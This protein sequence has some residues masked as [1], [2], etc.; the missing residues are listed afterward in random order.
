MMINENAGKRVAFLSL[1]VSVLSVIIYF[2]VLWLL[3]KPLISWLVLG[4]ADKNGLTSAVKFDGDNATYQY[5]LGRYYH[6][7]LEAPDLDAAVAYYKKSLLLSPLQAGVWNDLS[8]VY[9]LSGRFDNAEYALERAVK[10]NPNDSSLMWQAGT[11]YLINGMTDKAVSVLKKYIIIEPDRQIDVYDLCWKLKLDNSYI[12]RNLVPAQYAYQSRYLK[13]LIGHKRIEE[14][15]EVWKVIDKASVEKVF[16]VGYVNF[17]IENGLYGR[18]GEVWDEIIDKVPDLKKKAFSLI[19]NP[20]FD[21]EILNGGFDWMISGAEGVDIFV[22][23]SIRMTGSRSLGV[24]FDG[25]H[26]PDITVARQVVRVSPGTRY[27]L[28]GYIKTDA[29][30]TTNGIFF[31]VEG[32]KCEG[33]NMRSE[34]V[35]GTNFWR[36]LTVDFAVP[37]KCNAVVL[38]IKRERSNK[39]DNKIA[40]SAWIDG[41]TLKQLTD[42]TK[43][44]SKKP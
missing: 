39:F 15:D 9:Q 25:T 30:T 11:F 40:G 4:K 7:N 32:H 18:A 38:E 34:T 24:S 28:K 23:D 27:T 16:F 14:S 20:G 12:L 21:N 43:T 31:D 29:I 2:L 42:I 5:M 10:L 13:Y 22:D 19:W 26:N 3:A 17:L 1:G 36:E 44:A 41:L 33:L 6:L 35:T 8:K 37:S